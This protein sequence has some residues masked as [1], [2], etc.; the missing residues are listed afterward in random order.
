MERES[1]SRSPDR[2][3]LLAGVVLFIAIVGGAIVLAVWSDWEQGEIIGFLTAVIAL[4]VPLLAQLRATHS[5][6]QTLAKIDEQTNGN[7]DRRIQSGIEAAAT[8]AANQAAHN[9]LIQLQRGQQLPPLPPP[10]PPPRRR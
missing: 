7:L 1:S 6:N 9:T 10:P 5:Q 4:A 3:T 8:K 2:W